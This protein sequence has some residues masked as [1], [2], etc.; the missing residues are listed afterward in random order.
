GFA[1]RV[2][3]ADVAR[4]EAELAAYDED[5]AMRNAARARRRRSRPP[6]V[7]GDAPLVTAVVVTLAM[8]AFYAWTG[9]GRASGAW[10]AQGSADAAA[11]RAGELWRAVTALCLHADL[12]HLFA[13]ALFGTFFLAALGRSLGPGLALALYVLSG[14]GGNVVNAFLRST[15]HV[16]IGASTAV[17][18][19][20]GLLSGLG[21]VRRVQR[22][23][24]G[25]LALL[26][27]AAGLGILA[28]V[29]SGGGRVDAFAHLFGLVVGTGLGLG[30]A[31][32]IARPPGAL[33][34][35]ASGAA[36]VLLLW[37]CW[38]LAR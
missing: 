31:F 30:T 38:Q 14:T 9:P 16:S 27:L 11:M 1:L 17:F 29:G 23:D 5:V 36:A 7:E 32:T 33:S 15:D 25:R 20:V 13:N 21:V 8:V 24:R 2:A 19:A 37:A 26:P 28:M 22:G 12:A 6:E 35:T 4:A 10:F 34:Q 18:G 3:S